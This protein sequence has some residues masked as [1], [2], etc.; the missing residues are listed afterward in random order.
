MYEKIIQLK[1][2]SSDGKKYEIDCANAETLFRIIQ[3]IPSK[4]AEP[5]LSRLT[6]CEAVFLW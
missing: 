2:I 5:P 3:S 4:K 1:L 6:F